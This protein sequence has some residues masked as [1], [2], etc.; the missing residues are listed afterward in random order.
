M[1]TAD[2]LKPTGSLTRVAPDGGR[3]K[4]GPPLVNASVRLHS[5]KRGH[6]VIIG[7]IRENEREALL[8]LAVSTGLFMSEDAEALLGGV[9]D[10]LAAAALPQ[11]HTVVAC[12]ES[13]D[14]PALGW[15][16]YAPDAYSEKVWNVWWLGVSPR[17]HGG[18]VGQAILANIEQ[19]AAEEGARVIVIET[20]DQAPLARARRFYRKHGYEERGR[21]PDFYAAGESKVIFSRSLVDAA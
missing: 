6:R 13:H 8:G 5:Q 17:H 3:C 19:V 15:S 7:P 16:Y 1:W 21:I 4:H 18:G 9:L 20:S 10:S 12:R 14:G 11:G 2:E